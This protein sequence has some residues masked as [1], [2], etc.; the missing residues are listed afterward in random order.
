MAG[1]TKKSLYDIY[2]SQNPNEDEQS[3]LEYLQTDS[4]YKTWLSMS[5][6]ENKTKEE[7]FAEIFD[8]RFDK[9]KAKDTYNILEEPKDK[10]KT[11]DLID[12]LI[13]KITNLENVASEIVEF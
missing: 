9:L 4:A 13:L 11:Q 8:Y 3:F 7:F 5:G 6:N 1:I 2:K 12:A 10:F